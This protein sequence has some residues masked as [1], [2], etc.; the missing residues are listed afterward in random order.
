QGLPSQLIIRVSIC[1]E[2][3]GG[4]IA[5]FICEFRAIS[6]R[7][8][9]SIRNFFVHFLETLRCFLHHFRHLIFYVVACKEVHHV[10]EASCDV[11]HLIVT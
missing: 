11:G 7:S 3:F 8:N 10:R 9:D 6:I 2:E 4:A 1:L 5:D